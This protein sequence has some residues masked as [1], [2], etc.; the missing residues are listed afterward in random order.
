[1]IELSNHDEY[2]GQYMRDKEIGA[3]WTEDEGNRRFN[4]DIIIK[5][6]DKG[7]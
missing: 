3:E 6:I 1:M 5:G 2:D 4:R 7:I